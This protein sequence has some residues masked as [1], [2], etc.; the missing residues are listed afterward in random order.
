MPAGAADVVGCI[1]IAVTGMATWETVTGAER[2]AFMN[3]MKAIKDA[4]LMMILVEVGRERD[5]IKFRK[6]LSEM[7]RVKERQIYKNRSDPSK[8]CWFPR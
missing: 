1:W 7:E 4:F 3:A 8:S 5:V 6:K 2:Q